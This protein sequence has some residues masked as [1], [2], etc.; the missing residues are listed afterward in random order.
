M[1]K[2]VTTEQTQPSL[3]SGPVLSPPPRAPP[4]KRGLSTAVKRALG[5]IVLR[6]GELSV[7]IEIPPN[8]GRDRLRGAQPNIGV[9]V[10]GAMA[11]RAE[12][13][14]NYLQG[15]HAGYLAGLATRR[16]GRETSQPYTLETRFRY[17]PD[18]KSLVSMVP[19]VLP[20]LLIFIPSM[21]TALGGK[22]SGCPCAA[23]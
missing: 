12:T 16:F 11:Q 22:D 7:A 4:A 21:L 13:V 20:L 15:M 1:N 14:L 23:T 18:V 8:F 5:L 19:A 6:S 17:N 10:D 3:Q 2:N 9:W